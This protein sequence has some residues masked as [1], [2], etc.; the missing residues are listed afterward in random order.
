MTDGG[1]PRYVTHKREG[2]DGPPIP[3]DEPYMV[4]R[5]QDKL[6]STMLAFYLGLYGS[7][8]D[9]DRDSAVTAELM[10]HMRKLNRWQAMHPTK[11]AD[12]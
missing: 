6:A 7:L 9:K 12:R 1:N 8:P 3:D 10:E 11:Y 5:A 2:V 4:I